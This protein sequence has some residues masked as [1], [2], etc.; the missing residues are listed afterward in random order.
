[1]AK[2]N[3]LTFSDIE[4][5]MQM[6]EKEKTKSSDPETLAKIETIETKLKSRTVL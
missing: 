4:F 6:L 1:M 3:H 5:I 2:T